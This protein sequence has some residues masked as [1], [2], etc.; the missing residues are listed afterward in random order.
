MVERRIGIDG[1][2]AVANHLPVAD[3]GRNL[4]EQTLGLG[5]LGVGGVA[6][7]LGVEV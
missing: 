7:G 4:G 6:L 1:L 5:Q 2:L 3:D